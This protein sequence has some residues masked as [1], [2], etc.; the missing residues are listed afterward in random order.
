[1]TGSGRVGAELFFESGSEGDT[2]RLG[3]ALASVVCAGLTLSLNGQ[4]G[5][6]KTHFVRA[7]ATGLG[8]CESHVSSPTFVVLQ[9]YVDG[10]IPLAHFDVYRLGDVDEFLSLG[11]AEY[12]DSAEW[13]CLVEWGERL[14]AVLPADHLELEISH[15]GETSRRF[16]FRSTGPLSAGVLGKLRAVLGAV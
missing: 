2:G 1:M 6:G 10:R 7:L 4:L 11:G 8:V 9:Q 16:R 13:L 15:A 3:A 14:G 12:L 5:A